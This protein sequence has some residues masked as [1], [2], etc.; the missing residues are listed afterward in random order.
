MQKLVTKAAVVL[1]SGVLLVACSDEGEQ[2]DLQVSTSQTPTAEAS[3]DG[4]YI[5]ADSLTEAVE[6]PAMGVTMK[7]QGT[8]SSPYGG[9]VVMVAVTNDNE[10]PLSPEAL[11]G[12]TLTYSGNTA[13]LSDATASEG[14]APVH[15]PLDLPLGAGATANLQYTFDVNYSNLNDA[16]FTLGNIT[17]EGNLNSV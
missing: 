15:V 9:M 2:D 1:M 16:E 10:Q 5:V 11:G 17:F 6:D 14:S 13:E 4:E 3:Q 12:P 7:Y 8:T